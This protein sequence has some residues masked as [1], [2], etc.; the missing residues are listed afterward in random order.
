MSDDMSTGTPCPFC[1]STALDLEL[2]ELGGAAYRVECCSCGAAGPWGDESEDE[3]EARESAI[4][5]WRRAW[6]RRLA[7]QPMSEEQLLDRIDAWHTAE[8]ALS[9][10][11]W[12]GMSDEEYARW[13]ETGERRTSGQ[14]GGGEPR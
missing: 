4:A 6:R 7:S 1:D 8:T 9:L 3:A 12:L 11:E 5:A 2:D 13:V 10:P 14:A